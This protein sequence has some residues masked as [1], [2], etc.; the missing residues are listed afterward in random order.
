[1]GLV[2]E[3]SGASV[4]LKQSPFERGENNGKHGTPTSALE[5]KLALMLAH[6]CLLY[7]TDG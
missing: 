3:N 4:A 7:E 5:Q 1:M 6:D 2:S